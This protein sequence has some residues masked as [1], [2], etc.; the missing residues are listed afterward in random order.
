MPGKKNW[1]TGFLCMVVLCLS[2]PCMNAC[3]ADPDVILQNDA[4]AETDGSATD[5]A[6]TDTDASVSEEAEDSKEETADVQEESGDSSAVCMYICG[7]VLNP[8]VYELSSSARIYELVEM[9]GGLTEDADAQSVNMA[10]FA[11]DGGMIWIPT[12]EESAAGV[13]APAE[14][15]NSSA[16]STEADSGKVNI[17]TADASELTTLNGIGDSKAAAI[18]AYR[19]T[20]GAFQSIEEIMNVD[21][22]AEGTF[23]KIR[24]YI[25][26]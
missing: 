4:F 11:E 7:A 13:E 26:V 12:K 24:E 2:I 10:Q 18:I 22:I 3:S 14:A 1:I 6:E 20:H 16:A 19:D 23:E 17:N 5:T 9:A 8:G 15:A 25:T 21:G